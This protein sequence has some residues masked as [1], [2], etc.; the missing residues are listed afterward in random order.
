A[1][2]LARIDGDREHYNEALASAHS[3]AEVFASYGAAAKVVAARRSEAITLWSLR[4][5]R[6]AL[7][8]YHGLEAEVSTSGERASLWQNIA[9][10]YREVGEFEAE[11]RYFARAVEEV[12]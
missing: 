10:C 5:F 1:V 6:E 2:V 4:R 3:A 12:G 7:A 11:G 9:I 8:I